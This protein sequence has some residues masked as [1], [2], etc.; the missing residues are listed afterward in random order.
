MDELKVFIDSLSNPILVGC[1]IYIAKS[2]H[3]LNTK[4]AVVIERLHSHEARIER[5]EGHED[6]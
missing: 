2:I 4:I 5:L 3:E 1:A 6:K